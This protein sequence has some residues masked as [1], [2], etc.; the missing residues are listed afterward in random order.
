M[1]KVSR[2][3]AANVEDL[4]PVE[5]RHE[6]VGDRSINFVTFRETIDGT[7]L[8][9]G[10]PDDRCQCVHEGYVFRGRM[11][12]RFADHDETFEA[13]DAF[14]VPAGHA[15]LAEA[16]TEV[17]MF[18]PTEEMRAVSEAMARNAAAMAAGAG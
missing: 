13:G 1:P 18:S 10:L 6:E 2:D 12:F 14:Y 17:V 8:L 5:D 3:S 15:P 7:P 9:K 16:G 4:G 11:T